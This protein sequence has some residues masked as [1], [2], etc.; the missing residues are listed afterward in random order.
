MGS[1]SSVYHSNKYS[2]DSACEHCAGIIRHA[3]WCITENKNVLYAYNII[4]HPENMTEQ[5][6]IILHALGVVWTGL[7]LPAVC[8]GNCPKK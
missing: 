8:S 2:A 1:I 7:E 3:P 4:L 5:D 6:R